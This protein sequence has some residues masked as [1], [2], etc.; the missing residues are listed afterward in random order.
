[1]KLQSKTALIAKLLTNKDF[2][3]A[4]VYEHVRNGV[5]FQIRAMREERGWKQGKLG[6]ISGKPRNVISRLEN[7]NYGTLTLKTL[8]EMASAFEVALLVKFVPFSRLLREYTDTSQSA[9]SATGILNETRVLT[10][11]AQR[12]DH[13]NTNAPGM[14]KIQVRVAYGLRCPY[15]GI[16]Q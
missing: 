8:L 16:H 5:P 13:L 2:R 3:E 12:A 1:M 7:P 4:Y 15:R 9:L 10:K 11:W 14:Q 6:E